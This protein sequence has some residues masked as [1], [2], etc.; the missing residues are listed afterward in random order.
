[1]DCIFCRIISGEIQSDILYQD[2]EVIA[3]RDINPQAPTHFLV[4]P[5]SHIASLAQVGADQKP[6]LGHLVHVANELAKKEGVSDKGY[7]L[8]INSGA[9]AGQEVP[10]LHLHLLGG[11]PLGKMG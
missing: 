10:H 6:L 5:K 1:M 3:I 11:R 7:R 8:V 4:L 9:E 2:E